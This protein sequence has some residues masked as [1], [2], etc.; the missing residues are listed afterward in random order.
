MQI[1]SYQNMIPNTRPWLHTE[2]SV[3]RGH[4]LLLRPYKPSEAVL[5]CYPYLVVPSFLTH[6]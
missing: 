6:N 3:V 2:H 4:A 1:R 5:H